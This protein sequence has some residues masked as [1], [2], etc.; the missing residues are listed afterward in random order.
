MNWT[1]WLAVRQLWPITTWD[2]LFITRGTLVRKHSPGRGSDSD[3]CL[4]RQAQLPWYHQWFI[5]HIQYKQL[6]AAFDHMTSMSMVFV[7]LCN[8]NLL[9]MVHFGD[10][11]T[12]V[13][14]LINNAAYT[15]KYKWQNYRRDTWTVVMPSASS[16]NLKKMSLYD[17]F[18]KRTEG[19]QLDTQIISW[20]YIRN[21]DFFCLSAVK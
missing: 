6:T 4:V 21:E 15:I 16:N 1:C 8:H 10:F 17:Y 20:N 13:L 2:L 11:I 12:W 7:C 3:Q 9:K 19:I 18:V 14:V 5:Q